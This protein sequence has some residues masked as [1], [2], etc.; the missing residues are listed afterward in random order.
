MLFDSDGRRA[1]KFVLSRTALIIFGVLLGL[2][3]IEI[4]L[5]IK[6]VPNRFT[7]IKLLE[8]QWEPDEDLLLRLKP[9]LDMRI[10]GHPEFSYTVLTNADGLRDEP[11]QGAHDIAAIGDSFTFGFGVEE[12]HSWPARLESLSRVRVANLGWAGWSSLVYPTT[13]KRFAIPLQTRIWIWAF[14]SN[15]LPESAGAE[16]FLNSGEANYLDWIREI[17][18]TTDELHF[19][20]S[21]KTIQFIAALINPELFLLP[22]SGDRIYDDGQL[23]FRYGEYAW[24]TTDPSQPEVARGWELTE[25]ALLEASQLANIN[26]ATL[27]VVF[28]PYREHVYWPY[29]Q[30]QLGEDKGKQLDLVPARLQSFCEAHDIPYLNLLPGFRERALQGRM[31][32]FPEDGHWNSAGHDLA[33]GLIYDHLT[34]EGLLPNE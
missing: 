1:L 18:G 9:N 8:K 20:W 11:F 24:K 7:L 21:L 13:I 23:R 34:H 14:V 15:D 4:V 25:V 33:A 32:Y 26:Q 17:Q 30:D 22:N 31:L 2:T 10:T 16:A 5:R 19:P 3:L 28:V 27:I 29:L 12:P 6:P